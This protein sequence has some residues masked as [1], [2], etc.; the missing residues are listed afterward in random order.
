MSEPVPK[1]SVFF[2]CY[3]Q[4]AY[5]RRSL[6][7]VLAQRT[8]FPFEVIAVDDCST[9]GT[10]DI[11]AEYATAY[12]DRIIHIRHERN[13]YGTCS[14]LVRDVLPI[15]RGE[16]IAS[17]EGDDYWTDPDKLK[18]QTDFLDSHPD[19]CAVVSNHITVD[20]SE[21]T[22]ARMRPVRNDG[23]RLP[24]RTV[25]CGDAVTHTMP[26]INTA[27]YRAEVAREN[28]G[29][30][31]SLQREDV[32]GDISTLA[33]LAARGIAGQTACTLAYRIHPEGVYS[34]FVADTEGEPMRRPLSHLRKLEIID[35]A[36]GGTIASAV[37]RFRASVELARYHY[38]RRRLLRH[39]LRA[40]YISPAEVAS[41]L[42]YKLIKARRRCSHA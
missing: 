30:I 40:F 3:N 2:L 11:V 19:F 8:D 24:M 1:V 32:P 23:R 16:Y 20:E 13:I 31:D 9:D 5:V 28:A 18:L 26:H 33:T 29:I 4:A 41:L 10:S 42:R 12:P 25:L 39:L 35:R 27:M 36:T 17:L 22:T 6:E 15:A 38:T 14:F 34:R 37:R 7:S 21:R